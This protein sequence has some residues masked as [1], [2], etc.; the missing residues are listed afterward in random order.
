MLWTPDL[1][2]F[3]KKNLTTNNMEK[4]LSHLSFSLLAG[5]SEWII[6]ETLF[7]G[8]TWKDFRNF[9]A[10]VSGFHERRQKTVRS[11]EPGDILLGYITGVKRWVGAPEVIGGNKD[12][13]K[14]WDP[15]D[16]PEGLVVRPLLLLDPEF[17]VE[18]DVL[19]GKVDFFRDDS[20]QQ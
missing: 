11:I 9:G 13:R 12:T 18:M 7:T 6:G 20:D 17:G 14:I 3:F 16:F 4:G 5:V 15:D 1:S 10:N 2:S 8:S 19:K